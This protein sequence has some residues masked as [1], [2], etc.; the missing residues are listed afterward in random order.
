MAAPSQSLSFA[1]KHTK[2]R[3]RKV[4]TTIYMGHTISHKNRPSFHSKWQASKTYT[5]RAAYRCSFILYIVLY[6]TCEPFLQSH[7]SKSS[8]RLGQ[9][10]ASNLCVTSIIYIRLYHCND[11][12]A[13]LYPQNLPLRSFTRA[14]VI[15]PVAAPLKPNSAHYKNVLRFILYNSTLFYTIPLQKFCRTHKKHKN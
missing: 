4:E 1:K 15:S 14:S 7:L 10:P 11:T 3:N 6:F 5:T 13:P 9:I 12:K 2:T 8:P